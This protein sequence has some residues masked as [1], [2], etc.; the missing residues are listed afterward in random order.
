MIRPGRNGS[1]VILVAEPISRRAMVYLGE[2]CHVRTCDA[3]DVH[4]HVGEADGLV[5]RTYTRVDEALLER[6]RRLKVVGR[7]G[8]GL[9]N[10]DIHAC[11][12]R[13]IAVVHTPEANTA[14]VVDYT[15]GMSVAFNRRFQPMASHLDARQFHEVRKDAHGRFLSGMTLGIIGAGRIGSRVGRIASAMGMKILF[16]DIMKVNL[17]YPAV[18]MDKDSLYAASDIVTIHVPHT[19]LTNKSIDAAA[20][21]KF[22]AGAQ[23]INAARG[24]CVDYAALAEAIR[25]GHVGGCAIDCHDREPPPADYPMFGVL[26][27][28]VVLTPHIAAHVPAALEAMSDVAYDVI[29]V[30]QDRPPRYP[31]SGGAY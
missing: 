19:K 13:G 28:N 15:I 1:P 17:D 20:L 16:N 4:R 31:A 2:H 23:F 3:E 18:E 30:L 24:Q 11:L 26:S 21:A 9:E 5:V 7:A 6:A 27:E 8:V 29:N 14:A 10:I 12:H 22:K 25:S